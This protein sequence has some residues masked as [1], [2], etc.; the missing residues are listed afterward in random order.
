[1]KPIDADKL[2]KAM[3]ENVFEG[4][5]EAM[6]LSGCW[7]RYR[8]V[9]RVIKSQ[10]TV[11]TGQQWIPCE[12]RQ[13]EEVGEYLVTRY[14]D[15]LRDTMVDIARYEPMNGWYKAYPVIAWMPLPELYK[16]EA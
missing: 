2:M 12:E 4:D 15:S 10:P 1:M 7:I 3:Y 6:W 16:E 14:A 8:A 9:E 11:E 13:P 5:G